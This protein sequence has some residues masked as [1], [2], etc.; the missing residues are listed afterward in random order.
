MSGAIDSMISR[1]LLQP[2]RVATDSSDEDGRLVLV[3][4]RLVAVLVHLQDSGHDELTGSWFLEAGFGPC[5]TPA[6]ETFKSLN[7]A[8]IWIMDRL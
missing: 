2:I 1:I 4:G 6:C 8:Q 5:A 7:A 3:D